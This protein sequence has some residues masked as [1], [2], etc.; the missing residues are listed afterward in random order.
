[1]PPAFTVLIYGHDR[2]LLDT[3]RWVLETA[4]FR[5]FTV[6]KMENA[7]KIVADEQIDLLLLCHTLTAEERRAALAAATALRP[8]TK[9]LVMMTTLQEIGLEEMEGESLHIFAGAAGLIAATRKLL[10]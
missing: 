6:G 9:R 8:G 10:N 3:R 2:T 5:V 7:A 1:M 4:G